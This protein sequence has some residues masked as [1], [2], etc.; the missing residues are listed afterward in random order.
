MKLILYPWDEKDS[1]PYFINEE[2]VEWWV[3]KELTKWAT[4]D[5]TFSK[6]LENVVVFILRKNC[7]PLTRILMNTVTNE[8]ISENTNYEAFACK[9]DILR[10]AQ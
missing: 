1:K 6:G 3:D 10:I 7:E 5:R 8:V 9:I 4:Q 2:K